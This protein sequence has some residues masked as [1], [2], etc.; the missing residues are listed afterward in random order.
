MLYEFMYILVLLQ[1]FFGGIWLLA[2]TISI[3]LSTVTIIVRCVRRIVN[4]S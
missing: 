2:L 4:R 3:I 1:L